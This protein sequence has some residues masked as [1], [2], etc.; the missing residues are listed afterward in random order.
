MFFIAIYTRIRRSSSGSCI[1]AS[2]ALSK[3]LPRMQQRSISEERSRTGMC[4]SATTRIPFAF[5][6]E[7]LELRMASVM[8]LPVLMTV[9]TVCRSVSSRS[10]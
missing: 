4:A 9:S 2:I 10:R 6:S 8:G 5:A 1:L 7:I 3:R